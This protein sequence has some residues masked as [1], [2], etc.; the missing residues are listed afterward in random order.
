M[1]TAYHASRVH[2]QS[3]RRKNKK[4]KQHFHTFLTNLNFE[5]KSQAFLSFDYVYIIT[6]SI[7]NLLV[8]DAC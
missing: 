8:S 2:I 3:S 6:P 5:V 7:S 4:K 1:A